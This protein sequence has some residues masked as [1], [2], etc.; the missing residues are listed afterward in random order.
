MPLRILLFWDG[1]VKEL[2]FTP[3][4]YPIFGKGHQFGNWAYREASLILI[5]GLPQTLVSAL[6]LD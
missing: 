1:T 4:G 3:G 2:T 5:L 6:V